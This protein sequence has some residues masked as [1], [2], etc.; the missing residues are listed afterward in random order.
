M[1]TF[2]RVSPGTY[3]AATGTYTSPVTTTITGSAIEV[4]GNP[5]QYAALGL[6][7]SGAPTLLFTPTDYEL[8]SYT[9]EFVLPGDQVEWNGQP[10]TVKAV[11]PIAPDGIV[12][13]ARVICGP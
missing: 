7:Q 2:S 9:D 8:Q 11:F 12:I 1:T 6:T 5:Q 13:M 10:F 4:K 3:D